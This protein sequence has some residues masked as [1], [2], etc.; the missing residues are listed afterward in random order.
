[1]Y[2]TRATWAQKCFLPSCVNPSQPAL[3]TS[4]AFGV[5]PECHEGP[6]RHGCSMTSRSGK[7]RDLRQ[8]AEGVTHPGIMHHPPTWQRQRRLDRVGVLRER[9]HTAGERREEASGSGES[10]G[11]ALVAWPLVALGLRR[12]WFGFQHPPLPNPPGSVFEL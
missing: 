4:T 2:P 9:F 12:H 5:T 1:M 8:E 3:S 6:M 7:S 10:V 11:G